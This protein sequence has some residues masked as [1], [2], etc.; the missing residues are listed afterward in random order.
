M[1]GAQ[2]PIKFITPSPGAYFAS[3]QPFELRWTA[4]TDVAT[5]STVF[6]VCM[7]A[8]AHAQAKAN[9]SGQSSR[10]EKRKKGGGDEEGDEYG[11]E[12]NSGWGDDGSEQGGDSEQD[13]GS[14]QGYDG[15][16]SSGSSKYDDGSWDPTAG[17][18]D[19]GQEDATQGDLEQSSW[20]E[21]GGEDSPPSRGGTSDGSWKDESQLGAEDDDTGSAEFSLDPPVEEPQGRLQDGATSSYRPTQD[22]DTGTGLCGASMYPPVQRDGNDYT[23]SLVVPDIVPSSVTKFYIQ[24]TDPSGTARSPTFSLGT[25][26]L[27]SIVQGAGPQHPLGTDFGGATANGSAV[28]NSTTS[29]PIDPSMLM[30][31]HTPPPPTVAMAVPLSLVGGVLL[32]AVLLAWRSKKQAKRESE[33]V[34][35]ALRTHGSL[36]SMYGSKAELSQPQGGEHFMRQREVPV[37]LFMPNRAGEEYA[38]PVVGRRPRMATRDMPMPV[39]GTDMGQARSRESLASVYSDTH[40]NGVDVPRALAPARV[41]GRHVPD[42]RLPQ[43]PLLEED[44][45]DF[46][47]VDMS[48]PKEV[49]KEE[50]EG[51]KTHPDQGRSLYNRVHNALGGTG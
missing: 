6:R 2:L 27:S 9:V 31:S 21:P 37:P 1:G 42:K 13:Y 34:N 47:E 20:D 15:S 43:P 19:S 11:G 25:K 46:D 5:E 35:N 51:I 10:K 38:Q 39:Y 4:D 18:Y 23:V 7:K 16:S 49:D 30:A 29:T 40:A 36:S 24:V 14:D 32:V 44:E 45:D 8:P 50:L 28:G 3:G 12:G 48:D 22:T 17:S 33:A 41:R 26:D